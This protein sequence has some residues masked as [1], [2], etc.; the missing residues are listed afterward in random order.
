MVKRL[1]NKYGYPPDLE[2][3]SVKTVPARAEL[4]PAAW[5]EG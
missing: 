5:A 3:E 2:K 4:L 1:L